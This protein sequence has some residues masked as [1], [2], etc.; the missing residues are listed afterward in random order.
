MER[1][2]GGYPSRS[3]RPA[4]PRRTASVTTPLRLDT[5]A[6]DADQSNVYAEL[7][8]NPIPP[9]VASANAL[10]AR[11]IEYQVTYEKRIGLCGP[12]R[13]P[14]YGYLAVH[15]VRPCS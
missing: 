12:S 6:E 7:Y 15:I 11:G 5:K 2:S 13:P 10:R 14:A 4:I 8:W 1:T 3:S 9:F